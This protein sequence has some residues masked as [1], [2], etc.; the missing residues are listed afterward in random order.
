MR[1]QLSVAV[2]RMAGGTHVVTPDDIEPPKEACFWPQH[3]GDYPEQPEGW[4]RPGWR[5][6]RGHFTPSV[7]QTPCTRVG[8]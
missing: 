1:G 2:Q 3:A 5:L 4:G 7:G 8:L 6:L